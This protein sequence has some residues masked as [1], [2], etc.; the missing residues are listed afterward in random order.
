VTPKKVQ[1]A[2]KSLA[3][4]GMKQASVSVR[5]LFALQEKKT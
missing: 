1:G 4:P 3:Q 5:N 2:D